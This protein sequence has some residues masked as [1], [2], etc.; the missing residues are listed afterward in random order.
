[1]KESGHFLKKENVIEESKKYSSRSDFEKGNSSE[2][3]TS[4]IRKLMDNM[5]WLV[6]K[7]KKK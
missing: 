2:Y 5:V 4:L 3:H 6:S 1:M 7:R